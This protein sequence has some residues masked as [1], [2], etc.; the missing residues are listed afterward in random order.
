MDWYGTYVTILAR[1]RARQGGGVLHA[2]C[3][4]GGSTEGERRAGGSGSHGIDIEDQPGYTDRFGV[5]SFTQA[6]ALSWSK[7]TR[8]WS[9]RVLR[10]PAMQGLFNSTPQGSGI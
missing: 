2:F 9:L 8:V 6:D 1:L 3:G 4:G 5:E 7:V 10:Q